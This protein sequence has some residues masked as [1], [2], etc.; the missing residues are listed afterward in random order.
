MLIDFVIGRKVSECRRGRVYLFFFLS[1][2]LCCLVSPDRSINHYQH[3]EAQSE[4][5]CSGSLGALRS[6]SASLRLVRLLQTRNILFPVIL[7]ED[8]ERLHERLE[9][10]W[11]DA[12]AIFLHALICGQLTN[13]IDDLCERRNIC[14]IEIIRVPRVN[15][16]T[17]LACVEEAKN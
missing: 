16:H 14:A 1:L 17:K 8:L 2:I 15:W 4:I 10:R 5:N 12:V 7:K 13:L 3:I 11:C 6:C 9:A